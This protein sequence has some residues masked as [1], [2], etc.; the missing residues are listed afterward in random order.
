METQVATHI[1]A[2]LWIKAQQWGALGYA[3]PA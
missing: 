2:V 1:A 3:A